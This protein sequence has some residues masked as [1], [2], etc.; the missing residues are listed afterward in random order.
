MTG[1]PGDILDSFGGLANTT[2][3]SG[4]QGENIAVEVFI[5][6]VMENLPAATWTSSMCLG[7]CLPSDQDTITALIAQGDTLDFSFHFFTDA[8][9]PGPDT[10]WARVR[11]TNTN[12]SQTPV[13][14]MYRGITAGPDVV[15]NLNFQASNQAL[16]PRK[17]LMTIDLL[18][19]QIGTTGRHAQPIPGAPIL[20]IYD[21]GSVEKRVVLQ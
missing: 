4:V 8:L 13:T 12:G 16:R 11:F 10:A 5:E 14:R 18:G 21:D 6:R 17:L 3:L 19:R 1:D 9:M 2:P 15:E 20:Y 7:V